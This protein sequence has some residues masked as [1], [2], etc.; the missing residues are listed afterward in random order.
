MLRGHENW[1]SSAAFS[2]DG[3]RIVTG[4][5]DTTARVWDAATGKELAA[6]RG[7][8]GIVLSAGFSPDGSRVVS[9]SADKTARVWDVR[10]AVMATDGLIVEACTWRLRGLSVLTRDEMRLIG[11]PDDKLSIDVCAGV[12]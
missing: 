4:S 10:L 12:K 7:H 8:D 1:V 6:L 9:G 11:E 3:S 2:P 5:W